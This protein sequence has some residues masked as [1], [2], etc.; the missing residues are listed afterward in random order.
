VNELIEG[1]K[2]YEGK[3]AIGIIANP[4]TGEILAIANVPDYDPHKYYKVS[5][6]VRRNRVLTD[7]YEPGS[8]IKSIVMAMLLEEEIVSE[9]NVIDT[10]N[11]KFKIKGALIRDTHKFKKLNASRS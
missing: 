2:K 9:K 4:N 5:D 1:V 11:G 6:F 8:T 7:T 3:S 10:E